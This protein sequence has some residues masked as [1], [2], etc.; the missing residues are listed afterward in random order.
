MT[1]SRHRLRT[2]A[3]LSFAIATTGA[4]HSAMDFTSLPKPE[5][6]SVPSPRFARLMTLGFDA[7]FADYYWM[8]AVQVAGRNDND[9]DG[10]T[11]AGLLEAIVAIN[12]WV[13]HPYRFAAVWLNQSPS[14]VERANR[15]LEVGIAHHPVEWRNRYHLGFNQ[16]FYLDRPLLA[17]DTLETAIG[18]DGTPRYLPR[19]V[20]RLRSSQGGL[21][22]AATFINQLI[23]QADDEFQKA[24]YAKALDEIEIERRARFLDA[25]REE[26]W[27]RNG[28]DIERVSDL[29]APPNPVLEQLPRA[30]LFLEG[31]E[32]TLDG[33]TGRIVSSFYH[34]RYELH[35]APSDRERQKRWTEMTKMQEGYDGLQ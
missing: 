7:A 3:I 23:D 13:D 12:P 15:M 20:A 5:G 2:L 16:F 1:A 30:Q 11:T 6:I 28:R 14:I 21:A 34:S 9:E 22:V 27:R 25:A 26:Y 31:F 33:M 8:R 18:L 29:I 10:E 32:W 19:L 4:A 17:A 35:V 24:E